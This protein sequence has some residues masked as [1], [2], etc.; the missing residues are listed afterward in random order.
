MND[1]KKIILFGVSLELI[2][3]SLFFLPLI[4]NWSRDFSL[5]PEKIAGVLFLVG[6]S[7]LSFLVYWLAFRFFSKK[8]NLT[9]RELKIILGFFFLFAVTILIFPPM[10][11]T[12]IYLYSAQTRVL[13]TYG[14]N[15][16]I[17]P[18]NQFPNDL[19]SP[20]NKH[21]QNIPA[22]Y[23]PLWTII[24]A[25]VGLVARDNLGAYI[26]GFRFLSLIFFVFTGLV[27]YKIA[28][29]KKNEKNFLVWPLFFWNPL[30]L[31]EAVN[32]GHND[33]TMAFFLV[34]AILF[35]FQK[36]FNW[37]IVFLTLSV[38]IKYNTIILAP[39]FLLGAWKEKPK[40]K[41]IFSLFGWG[42]IFSLLIILSAFYPFWVGMNTFA[43]LFQMGRVSNWLIN[44]SPLILLLKVMTLPWAISFV[45]LRWMAVPFFISG[46]L[47]FLKNY[48]FGIRNWLKTV[49]FLTI[50]F[51]GTLFLWCPAWYFLW[52]I[53]LF[54]IE[55]S[56]KFLKIGLIFSLLGLIS[57]MIAL[58]FVYIFCIFILLFDYLLLSHKQ[59]SVRRLF[60]KF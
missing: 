35:Y 24:S 6:F 16:Y 56:R 39:I 33:S 52:V 15:P 58:I 47:Y 11:S 48:Y 14:Q 1:R 21:W 13:T 4:K 59:Y 19:F 12:D 9:S 28:I 50:V 37:S 53:P 36:K 7:L 18:L 10:G 54:F 22:H 26:F 51:L 17:A 42:I 27:I 8:E 5:P 32:N 44:A 25:I 34:M 3:L 60:L 31:W 23:G 45:N 2:F 55:G 40:D 46:Y 49:I 43:G 38:L 57:S 41:S 29:L 30:F 20:F